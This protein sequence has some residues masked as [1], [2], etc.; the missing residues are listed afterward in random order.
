MSCCV[1]IRV[2]LPLDLNLSF[3]ILL[4][5]I[6]EKF[7]VQT[8]AE[9][10]LRWTNF[11]NTILST[12]LCSFSKIHAMSKNLFAFV[13]HSIQIHEMALRMQ[14]KSPAFS[15]NS[16][17]FDEKSSFPCHNYY[18]THDTFL[19][20]FSFPTKYDFN[21]HIIIFLLP[22]AICFLTKLYSH[23]FS[24]FHSWLLSLALFFTCS[25]SLSWFHSVSS[26]TSMFAKTCI[27]I[28]ILHAS[29]EET[30]LRWH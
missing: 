25:L 18:T 11:E 9:S 24:S 15:L 28:H 30:L 16:V 3:S 7:I 23:L 27:I 8:I 12:W 5:A 4:V 17:L 29:E 21:I 26:M 19:A 22:P 1:L 20:T 14:T 13:L 2:S 6:L 10:V